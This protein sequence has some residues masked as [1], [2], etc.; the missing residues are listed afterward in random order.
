MKVGKRVVRTGKP[1]AAVVVHGFHDEGGYLGRIFGTGC[2]N[3]QR[4][5]GG[6]LHRVVIYK[7]GKMFQ[8]F[9]QSY[10]K[11]F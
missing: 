8:L 2:H 4:R 9:L 5:S 11:H 6:G 1:L 3:G 7:G 10:E